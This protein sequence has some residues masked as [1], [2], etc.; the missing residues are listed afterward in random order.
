[1]SKL[2]IVGKKDLLGYTIP[3]MKWILHWWQIQF[4]YVEC[5][6]QWSTHSHIR[7][8]NETKMRKAIAAAESHHFAI[9]NRT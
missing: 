7:L 6:K 4:L 3:K 8:I 2:E 9:V 5:K 1:M